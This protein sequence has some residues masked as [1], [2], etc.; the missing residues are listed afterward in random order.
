MPSAI[1]K[2]DNN[3][4]ESFD[5]RLFENSKDGPRWTMVFQ[6]PYDTLIANAP[7]R[8]SP[9]KGMPANFYVDT[10][11]VERGKGTAGKMTLTLT[12]A[13]IEDP[14]QS[15]N[16]V[17]EVEFVEIQ[18]KLETHP[19]FNAVTSTSSHPNA[20]KYE[21]TKD[22]RDKIEEWKNASTAS[23]RD[24][25]YTALHDNAQQ[26]ADRIMKGMDSYIVFAPLCRQ[27]V[28]LTSKP[29]NTRCGFQDYPPS[30]VI[31]SGYSY[32]QT[33]DRSTRDRNWS[34]VKEW[35]G[36][37]EIDTEIYAG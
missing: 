17:L 14:F 6:G 11:R 2:G 28:K 18:K 4:R 24:T 26:F 13:P 12:P 35:T 7:S 25:A 3:T 22:D 1:W 36:A 37:D 27:T 16:E 20:G 10:V 32:L 19:M 29:T 5:S 30:E 34:R 33:A 15:N 23:E 8:M 21:L 31:V 9:V